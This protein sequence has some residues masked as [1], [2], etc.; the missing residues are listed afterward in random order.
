MENAEHLLSEEMAGEMAQLCQFLGAET[1]LVADG[2]MLVAIPD[3]L[4]FN[5][6]LD[7]YYEFEDYILF[8][9]WL[10]PYDILKAHT[11]IEGREEMKTLFFDIRPDADLDLYDSKL[12]RD[13]VEQEEYDESMELYDTFILKMR[14][15]GVQYVAQKTYHYLTDPMEQTDALDF[16]KQ[17]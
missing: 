13:M 10:E 3:S 4:S 1:N 6:A 16:L 11:R 17:L 15:L 5:S 14:E 2:K 7:G 9:G 12:F 8:N